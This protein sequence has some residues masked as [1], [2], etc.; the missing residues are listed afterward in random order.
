MPT[1]LALK[2]PTTAQQKFHPCPGGGWPLF[3]VR[4]GVPSEAALEHAANLLQCAF[5]V[6]Q[7]GADGKPEVMVYSLWSVMH[8]VEAANAVVE[9]AMQ[10]VSA[11]DD[12]G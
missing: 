6:A 4:P 8:L 10:G 3:S 11:N 5:H 2:T 12:M 7:Q 9:A 1:S